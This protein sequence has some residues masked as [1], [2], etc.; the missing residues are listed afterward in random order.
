MLILLLGFV[1]VLA[2]WWLRERAARETR[3]MPGGLHED[4]NVPFT[5]EYE[6]YDND[7]SLCSKKAR[8]CLEELGLPY[9]R[10]RIDL[11]E[12][13]AYQNI[14]REFLAVNPA[15]IVPVLVHKGHPV[16]ESHD[17]IEYAAARP[18]AQTSL[19]PEDPQAAARMR[20]WVEKSSILGDNPQEAMRTNAGSCIPVLTIPLFGTM[21]RYIPV[22]RIAEGLLFHRLKLRPLLFLALKLLGPGGLAHIP[23]A[24]KMVG[25]ACECLDRHLDEF[26]AE[27]EASGG[28]WILGAEFSLAD[29]SWAV[30]LER[31]WEADWEERFLTP[32]RPALSAYWSRLKERPSYDGA[33]RQVVHATVA[34]GRRDLVALKR[35]NPSYAQKIYG[36][37]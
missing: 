31:L 3:A 29:V 2:V 34:R 22:S 32:E 14:G 12:T 27:L 28:P 15:A 26:E 1:L 16:Y 9:K 35:E 10:H 37:P 7:F 13:G 20:Y 8:M 36:S 24:R 30:M 6:L 5:E 23:P 25:L 4:R 18:E 17:I 33:M 21:I 11:I 19:V